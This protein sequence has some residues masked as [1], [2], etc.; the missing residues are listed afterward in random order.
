MSVPLSVRNGNI[1]SKDMLLVSIPYGCGHNITQINAFFSEN[2]NI[3]ITLTLYVNIFFYFN[4][5]IISS[6]TSIL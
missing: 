6:Q 2:V 4:F 3:K 5:D 1:Q